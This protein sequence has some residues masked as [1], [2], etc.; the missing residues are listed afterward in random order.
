MPTLVALARYPLKSARGEQL[1]TSDL[2]RTGLTGDRTWACIDLRDETIGSAKHP[3]RW[4][5]LLQVG[6]ALREP[7]GPVELALDGRSYV[8]GTAEADLALSEHLGHPVRLTTEPPPD[9]RL[10]RRLPDDVG[11]VPEWMADVRPGDETVTRVTGV[12]RVGR[13]VDFGAVHVVT[14]GALARLG[15]RLGG[16]PAAA[17]R[18]RANLVIDA[19]ADPAPGDELQVG[20]VVLRVVLPTPRCIV[21][22]L[23]HGELPADRSL[24]TALARHYRVPVPGLG[25]AACFGTYA[26]VLRP[27]RLRLGQPVRSRGTS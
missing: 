3:L 22:G 8:A 2:D 20:D 17:A 23:A 18:F 10:R 21:P 6:A 19:P 4:G 27:G 15:R 25:R 1:E 26:D 7:D 16:A 12:G 24:L 9:P 13:F 14:T 5:R 11:L